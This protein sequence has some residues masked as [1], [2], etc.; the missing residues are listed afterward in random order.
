MEVSFGH[1]SCWDISW[2]ATC[3]SFTHADTCAGICLFVCLSPRMILEMSAAVA[4]SNV[5]YSSWSQ[6]SHPAFCTFPSSSP[7]IFVLFFSPSVF[8]SLSQPA[9]NL[10]LGT[11]SNSPPPNPPNF[12]TAQL[13]AASNRNRDSSSSLKLLLKN[14]CPSFLGIVLWKVPPSHPPP[15][16]LHPVLFGPSWQTS[17][18]ALSNSL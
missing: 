9:D 5:P 10:T 12:A 2:L 6:R 4:P 18:L 7:S 3:V 14:T 8:C 11:A 16:H 15:L 13:A 1:V 17:I